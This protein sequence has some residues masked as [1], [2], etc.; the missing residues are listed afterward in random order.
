MLLALTSKGK[1]LLDYLSIDHAREL[2]DLAP[3][4]IQT[5]SE[6]KAVSSKP[7]KRVRQATHE[8]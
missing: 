1:R 6:L 7:G 3:Q 4:L 5:L 8:S 2:D